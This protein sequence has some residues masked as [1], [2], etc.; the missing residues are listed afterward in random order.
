MPE[1]AWGLDAEQPS[2][3]TTAA[4]AG[5][6]AQRLETTQRAG[7]AQSASVTHEPWATSYDTGPGGGPD[8]GRPPGIPVRVSRHRPRFGVQKSSPGVPTPDGGVQ[9]VFAVQD[10]GMQ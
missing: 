4:G 6:G 3:R 10:E 2:H 5:A 7:A 1:A 8:P 9:S